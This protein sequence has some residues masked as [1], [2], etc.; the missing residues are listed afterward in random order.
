[1]FLDLLKTETDALGER[2]LAEA[3]SFTLGTDTLADGAIH[4]CLLFA[5][6]TRSLHFRC[7]RLGHVRGANP[8]ANNQETGLSSR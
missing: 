4:R 5:V 1:M 7:R 3:G 6:V 8:G 2:N